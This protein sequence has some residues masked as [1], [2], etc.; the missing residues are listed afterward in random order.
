M[1]F[2]RS[3]VSAFARAMCKDIYVCCTPFHYFQDCPPPRKAKKAKYTS[4]ELT[5]WY[6][7]VLQLKAEKLQLQIKKMKNED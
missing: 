2:N 6:V 4:A 3:A 5:D 7:T 1:S